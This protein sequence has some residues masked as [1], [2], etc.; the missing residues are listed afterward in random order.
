MTE[1]TQGT[2]APQSKYTE[3]KQVNLHSVTAIKNNGAY[4]SD[5]IFPFKNIISNAQRE[6]DHCLF[7]V[8]NCQFPV[9]FYNIT[10]TNNKLYYTIDAGAQASLV[11]TT[12]NYNSTTLQTEILQQLTNVGITNISM[13]FSTITGKYTFTISSGEFTFYSS[14]T[15]FKILGFVL[16]VNH[17]SVTQNLS[18]TYPINL[19]GALKLKIS[20]QAIHINN[21]D[22]LGASTNTLIE[23]P[24]S[25]AN[26]GLI[27]YHNASNIYNVLNQTSLNGIDILIMDDNSNLVN[28]NG[29]EW[30]MSFLIKIIYK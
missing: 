7:S 22:S 27:L 23:V 8:E 3:N 25:S 13:T 24:I 15:I 10:T 18:T 12:G 5:V 6:I 21:I 9:S 1:Q 16:G 2:L 14:S 19:L 29:Q 26:F 28:F 4:N 17:T 11:I 30:A 20:S